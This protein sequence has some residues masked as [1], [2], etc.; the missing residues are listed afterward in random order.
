MQKGISKS[1]LRRLP[2]Y[3]QYL[4]SLPEV[5]TSN[6]S[7]TMLAAALGLGEV[8][9]RKDLALVSSSG[10][11]KIGY[12]IKDLILEL[13][14]FLGYNNVNDAVIIGAGKLGK[15]LLEFKGFEQY[16][17]NIVAAFDADDNKVGQTDEAKNIFPISEFSHLCSRLKIHIGIITVP[18]ESAQDV[19]NQMIQNGIL[20]I[21]NFAPTHLDVPPN[22]LVHNENM[23]ASLAVLSNHLKEQ[24]Q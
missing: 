11:P 1:A 21:W 17:L 2:V 7:A 4:K 13:E 18:A 9:V 8:Q 22:I 14:N 23:A 16:G 10:R 6:I 5:S 15:A 20:A 12:N 19:C 24:I 3:L